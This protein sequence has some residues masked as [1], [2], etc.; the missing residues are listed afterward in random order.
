M[1]KK[2]TTQITIYII[3]NYNVDNPI[4]SVF[5]LD[6]L[7]M[8]GVKYK[9]EK[10]N[11]GIGKAQTPMRQKNKKEFPCCQQKNSSESTN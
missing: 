9:Y 7:Y 5:L 11:R 6:K 1:D 4:S 3:M 8:Y 10:I 2:I